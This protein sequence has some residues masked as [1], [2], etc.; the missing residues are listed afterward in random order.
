MPERRTQIA[1]IGAGPSGLLLGQLLH[2]AGIDNV[3]LERRSAGYVL[4][5]V[6]AG[7]LEQT[8]A[9]LLDEAGVGAR[10]RGE[11]LPHGGIEL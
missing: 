3:I 11:G 9:D 10:M 5:R 1:I 2:N 7:V 8:T 6:R 4:A